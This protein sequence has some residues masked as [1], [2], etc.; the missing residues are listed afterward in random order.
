[1]AGVFDETIDNQVLV[2]YSLANH[3]NLKINLYGKLYTE[4]SENFYFGYTVESTSDEATARNLLVNYTEDFLKGVNDLGEKITL[5]DVTVI[6]SFMKENDRLNTLD[7]GLAQLKLFKGMVAYV[8]NIKGAPEPTT[9]SKEPYSEA[10][11]KATGIKYQSNYIIQQ[12]VIGLPSAQ[13]GCD[14]HRNQCQVGIPLT[15]VDSNPKT[16]L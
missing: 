14:R 4:D 12:P 7:Q 11:E 6:I 13:I 1:M 9:L 8:I 10:Y 2:A 3:Y 5:K 16:K 15:K